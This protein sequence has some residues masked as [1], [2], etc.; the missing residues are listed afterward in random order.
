[1]S[2]ASYMGEPEK[3]IKELFALARR[4]SPCILFL[5]EADAIFWGIDSTTN[6]ILAQVKA[7]LSEITPED[8]IVVIAASNKEHLID[9]AT[10][11]R[12]EPN[13]YYVHPPL[14]DEEWNEVVSVHLAKYKQFLSLIHI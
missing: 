11:D 4:K 7:E 12:F 3:R 2:G 10:R 1:M 13:I 5:D 9:P 8:R 14:N 6:K